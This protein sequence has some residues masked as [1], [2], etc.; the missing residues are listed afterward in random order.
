MIE[1]M[2]AVRTRSR[3]REDMKTDDISYSQPHKTRTALIT[4]LFLVVTVAI[5]VVVLWHKGILFAPG[6]PTPPPTPPTPPPPGPTPPGPTPPGPTPPGPTPP[7]P[8][9]TPP[10]TQKK[11]TGL[12]IGLSVAGAIILIIGITLVFLR[13]NK[14]D[15][16]RGD[17]RLP[18]LIEEVGATEQL[19]KRIQELNTIPKAIEKDAK[20]VVSKAKQELKRGRED[21]TNDLN[22]KKR[23]VELAV[24]IEE[25]ESGTGDALAAIV[26]VIHA[27]KTSREVRRQQRQ[28]NALKRRQKTTQ[29]EFQLANKK[30]VAEIRIFE[31]GLEKAK[32]DLIDELRKKTKAIYDYNKDAPVVFSDIY[33]GFPPKMT[34]KKMEELLWKEKKRFEQDRAR[35]KR[36][37]E[38][39]NKQRI[40]RIV[41]G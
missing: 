37:M 2:S 20:A 31:E 27:T 1:E 34:S 14:K 25:I 23:K 38:V 13:M 41:A 12:I 26:D 29:Q 4:V 10:L 6:V 8:T 32:A 22:L 5:V 39:K 21:V 24:A 36:E 7:G 17:V 40:A 28:L 16:N 3:Y 9:P 15:T 35:L 30:A 11:N 33:I 18:P 19:E